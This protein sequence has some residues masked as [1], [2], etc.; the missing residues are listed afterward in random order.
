MRGVDSRVV[1][2]GEGLND[3]CET[4]AQ[5]YESNSNGSACWK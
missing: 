1:A 3:S 5:G 2:R 4:N